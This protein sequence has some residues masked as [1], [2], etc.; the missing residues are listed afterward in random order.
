MLVNLGDDAASFG[1]DCDVTLRGVTIARVDAGCAVRVGVLGVGSAFLV[2]G[3]RVREGEVGTCDVVCTRSCCACTSLGA[4]YATCCVLKSGAFASLTSLVCFDVVLE[5]RAAPLP[6]VV[7]TS[8]ARVL[9]GC[10]LVSLRVLLLLVVTRLAYDVTVVDVVEVSARQVVR[11]TCD[12]D[13]HHCM[14]V[15]THALQSI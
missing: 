3:A 8:W 1:D 13:M 11:W 5:T 12:L 15:R 2:A 4:L 7:A 14:Q 9:L 6:V 10:D